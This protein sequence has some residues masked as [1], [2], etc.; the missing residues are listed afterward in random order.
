MC[1]HGVAHTAYMQQ[2]QKEP[3]GKHIVFIATQKLLFSKEE[4]CSIQQQSAAWDEYLSMMNLVGG[5]AR[6]SQDQKSTWYSV[7]MAQKT[8]RRKGN[9]S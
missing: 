9:C 8:K 3:E 5:Y 6:K 7:C 2:W 4:R 1:L